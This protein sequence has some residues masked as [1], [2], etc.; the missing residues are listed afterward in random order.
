MIRPRLGIGSFAYRY[1]IGTDGFHPEKP[2]SAIG[3]LSEAYTLGYEGVQLCENLRY[4]GLS[5]E[6]LLEIRQAAG[7]RGLFLE[8]GMRTLTE[9]NLE[10]HLEIAEILSSKFLRIVLGK[11]TDF[12]ADDPEKLSK[13]SVAILKNAAP[14]LEKSGLMIGLENH[15]DLPTSR[16]ADIVQEVDSPR[17]GMVFD[18]TNALGFVETPEKTLE[19]IGTRLLSAH[20][21]DYRFRKTEAGYLMSGTILGE[22]RLDA[23]GLLRSIVRINPAASIILE[24]TIRK[25]DSQTAPETLRWEKDAIERSTQRLKSILDKIDDRGWGT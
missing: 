9:E 11:N 12:P 19:M 7:E 14:R 13:T 25:E 3:F 8:I 23:E 4:A 20:I 1:H 10:R 6:G 5:R 18:T 17:V 15:F 24:M 21:K 22:G 2:M 16:L